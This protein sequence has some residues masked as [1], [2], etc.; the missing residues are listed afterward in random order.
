[1][2]LA[3]LPAHGGQRIESYYFPA[4]ELQLESRW[5]VPHLGASHDAK[6]NDIMIAE[7]A[8]TEL[9]LVVPPAFVGKRVRIDAI[10]PAFA[11]GMEGGRGLEVEWRTQGV[12]RPGKLHMGERTPIFEG[13]ASGPILS[14]RVAY[15]IRT[16]AHYVLG[17]IRFET[18]YEIEET[19]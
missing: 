15:V 13:I 2:M 6:L 5:L 9:R 18:T 17:P 11:Q 8:Y 12:F 10:L 14:D 1:M 4:P 3:I 19:P 7:S 16:D